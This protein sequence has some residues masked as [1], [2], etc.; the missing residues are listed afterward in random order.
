[1]TAAAGCFISFEGGEGTGK[2]TQVRFLTDR[3]EALGY[4]VVTA[5]E[6]GGTPFGELA[7]ALAFKPAIFRRFHRMLSGVEWDETDPLAELFLM[8]AARAQLVGQVILPALA[9]GAVVICDRFDDSTLAYQGY[10]RGL[11][12]D[13]LRTVNAIATRELHPAL[14][15]L[16]DVPPE[17]GLARKRGEV[18]R[19][20]IGGAGLAFHRRV[21]DGYRQLAAAEPGRW[22]LLDG[23]ASVATLAAEIWQRV[24]S[25]LPATRKSSPAE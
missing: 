20:A 14:T 18:G 6:P 7:R 2:S 1:M 8:S 12:L 16:I 21:R 4:E 19:D 17:L 9:R 5:R 22:L 15:V 23:T 11:D 10:G 13:A 3:L 24:S 25:L